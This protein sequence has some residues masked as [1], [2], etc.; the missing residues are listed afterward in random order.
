MAYYAGS[1]YRSPLTRCTTHVCHRLSSA[2]HRHIMRA[3][4]THCVSIGGIKWDEFAVRVFLFFDEMNPHTHTYSALKTHHHLT[5]S[6]VNDDDSRIVQ[7]HNSA[8]MRNCIQVT[9]AKLKCDDDDDDWGHRN[10]DNDEQQR[11]PVDRASLCCVQKLKR[12]EHS[13]SFH[14]Q[15]EIKA[16]WECLLNI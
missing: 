12:E 9:I 15:K 3:Q 10:D 13:A 16:L 11:V 1:T 14:R 6:A 5:L 7:V 2:Y 4:Y 8:Y